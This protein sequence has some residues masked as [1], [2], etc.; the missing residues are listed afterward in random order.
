MRSKRADWEKIID[1]RKQEERMKIFSFNLIC[2]RQ[3]YLFYTQKEQFF[4]KF[5]W[6]YTFEN[7]FFGS[8]KIV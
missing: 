1:E 8:S 7:N 2:Y 6:M 5:S 3:E 4:L